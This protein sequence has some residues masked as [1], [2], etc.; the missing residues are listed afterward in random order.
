MS[1]PAR[2]FA[3]LVGA[4]ASFGAGHV[5]PEPP[6]LGD[7]LYT[8]LR[9]AYSATWGA[10]DG[11]LDVRFREKFELGMYDAWTNYSAQVQGL[12]IDMGRAFAR[13][14]PPGDGSDHYTA[15]VR[16]LI[17]DRLLGRCVIASLNY[18]CILEEAATALGPGVVY[19]RTGRPTNGLVVLKPHGSCNLLPDRRLDGAIIRME[20]VHTYYEGKLEPRRL[21]EIDAYYESGPAIPPAMSLYAPGKDTPVAPK[22]VDRSRSEWRAVAL[23]AN[24]VAVI[25]VRPIWDDAHIWDPVIGSRA[26]LWYIGDAES[27]RDLEDRAGRRVIHLARTFSEGLGPLGRLMHVLR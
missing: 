17:A 11:E 18:D 8:W 10:V 2:R 20:N 4:G 21:D 14:R 13:F 3:V 27:H 23:A 1:R 6:P 15:L 25:G 19:G 16:G 7:Q 12:L 24:A 22:W 9:K 26:D 5:T